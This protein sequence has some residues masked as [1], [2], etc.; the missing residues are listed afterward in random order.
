MTVQM[1]VDDRRNRRVVAELVRGIF[2]HD[3]LGLERGQKELRQDVLLILGL[4][5]DETSPVPVDGNG[6]E[7]TLQT[8]VQASALLVLSSSFVNSE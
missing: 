4:E 7:H 1:V 5:F 8:K 2:G 6:I 3:A